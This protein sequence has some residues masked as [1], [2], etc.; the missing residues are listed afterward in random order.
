MRARAL[1]V[2]LVMVVAFAAACTQPAPAP[3]STPTPTGLAALPVDQILAQ[4]KDAL[5]ATTF[6]VKGSPAANVTADMSQ[7]GED[8]KGTFT[9]FGQSLDVIYVSKDLYL[10]ASDDFWKQNIPAD[11]QPLVLPLISGKWAKVNAN[12]PA[13]G[14][15]APTLDSLFK[16]IGTPTKGDLTTING[17]PAI[18][19]ADTSGGKLYVATQGPPVVLRIE[20]SG[21]HLDFT[22]FGSAITVE[23]PAAADVVDLTPYT[24]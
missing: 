23:A 3:S 5:K 22:E 1:L 7:K 12:N 18:T 20:S 24:S 15:F 11:K 10:K 21:S 17:T 14:N 9:I 8:G 13:F 4:A 2:P 19:L 16:L 6:H